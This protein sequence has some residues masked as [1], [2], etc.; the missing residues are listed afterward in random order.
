[1]AF[2]GCRR[3]VD[4]WV[5]A[6]KQEA[7]GCYDGEGN[8]RE[9]IERG[10]RIGIRAKGFRLGFLN[11]RINRVVIF[12]LFK[13][14]ASRFWRHWAGVALLSGKRID[15]RFAVYGFNCGVFLVKLCWA[16]FAG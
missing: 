10:G 1:M 15:F 11:Y 3:F 14:S 16:N 2:L 12:R 13:R 7:S 4:R 8:R 6:S 5:G 9:V